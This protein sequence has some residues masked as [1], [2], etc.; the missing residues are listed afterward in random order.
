MSWLYL[1]GGVEA[2]LPRGSS[3]GGRSVT[4]KKNRTQLRSSRRGSATGS[5][6]TL[7][8]GMTAIPSTGA[9]GP[10]QWILSLRDSH[11]NHS[12][13]P[14]SDS[15]KM[16]HE[17]DGRPWR[18]SSARYDRVTRSWRT[19]P[20]FYPDLIS[21]EFSETWPSSGT[22][23]NGSLF[24][25]PKSEHRTSVIGCG[26]LPTPKAAR[27]NYQ[28]S[29]GKKKYTLVGMASAN[30]WPTP[31]GTKRDATPKVFKRG[32]RNLAGAVRYYTPNAGMWKNRNTSKRPRE[33][34]HQIG[35][36]LNPDWTEWLM[37]WPIGWTALKPLATGRFRKWLAQ[38]G[39][40]F[41]SV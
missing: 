6:M 5:S 33:I 9:P 14:A 30:L 26:F 24:P 22:M 35:G 8:S 23:R 36:Q 1:R 17:T 27:G 13:L 18:G 19:S 29:H 7:Q 20:V 16:I 15:L 38:H 41:A 2:F 10:E 4:S 21:D 32:N 11:A 3:G 39:G 40:C 25:R 12:A 37:G 34:A 31:M 28:I